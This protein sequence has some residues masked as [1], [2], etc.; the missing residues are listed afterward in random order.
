[1]HLGENLNF[2]LRNEQGAYY[3]AGCRKR[4]Y[5]ESES[6]VRHSG[7]REVTIRNPEKTIPYWIPDLAR[8]RRTRPV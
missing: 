5:S 4:R 6:L 7:S 1:M 2:L 3:P 8:H